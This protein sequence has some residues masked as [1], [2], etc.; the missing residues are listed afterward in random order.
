[1][2]SPQWRLSRVML[3]DQEKSIFSAKKAIDWLIIYTFFILSLVLS[4]EFLHK[5]KL[6]K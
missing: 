5:L 2:P 1:M 4:D 3:G 6:V